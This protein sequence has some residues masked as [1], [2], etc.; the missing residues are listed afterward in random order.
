MEIWLLQP[1]EQD[2][3]CK[4]GVNMIECS[5]SITMCMT[6]LSALLKSNGGCGEGMVTDV[7]ICVMSI[8]ESND[9]SAARGK[10]RRDWLRLLI[11]GLYFVSN[12]Y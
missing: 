3:T 7:L 10:N 12:V 5:Y 8:E 6:L 2:L 9:S 4:K 1:L 11:C